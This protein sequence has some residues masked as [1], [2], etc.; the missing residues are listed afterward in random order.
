MKKSKRVLIVI[1][2]IFLVCAVTVFLA[3]MF[4]SKNSVEIQESQIDNT[5]NNMIS[6]S[7]SPGFVQLKNTLYFNHLS[8]LGLNEGTYIIE[9]GKLEK[10]DDRIIYLGDVLNNKLLDLSSE[11]VMYFDIS[12][13]KFQPLTDT[14]LPTISENDDVKIIKNKFYSITNSTL[15]I[16]D[17]NQWK[18]MVDNGDLGISGDMFLWSNL[19]LDGDFIYYTNYTDEASEVCRYNCVKKII[20]RF[21]CDLGTEQHNM[22][23]VY[24]DCI[25]I[26]CSLNTIKKIDTNTNKVTTLFEA[27]TGTVTMNC[28]QENV[29]FS[30]SSHDDEKGF[31]WIDKS[32]KVTK[33]T[34][35][36]VGNINI[37]DEDYVYFNDMNFSL[38]RVKLSDLSLEKIFT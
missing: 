27:Q 1:A 24:K 25:C 35:T 22:F 12:T 29:Y 10:I 37:V 18:K 20:E 23:F 32:G 38:Y 19:Y 28:Y 5:Y 36:E 6:N 16:F 15:F 8:K 4:M 3:A 17:E 9:K 14:T 33:I 30:V 21:P 13:K 2:S 34:D 31:Y 26:L 11:P 7:F